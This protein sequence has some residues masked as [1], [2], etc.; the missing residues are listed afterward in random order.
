[1]SLWIM[2]SPGP[3][4]GYAPEPGRH[5]SDKIAVPSPGSV[6]DIILAM[7]AE[8]QEQPGFHEILNHR[9]AF[10]KDFSFNVGVVAHRF[11]DSRPAAY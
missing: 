3:V 2:L 6:Q 7:A 9:R 10:G 1:M 8:K 5:I 11:H 4:V